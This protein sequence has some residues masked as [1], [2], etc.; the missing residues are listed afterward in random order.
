M[1]FYGIALAG[2]GLPGVRHSFISASMWF[3]LVYGFTQTCLTSL[4][5]VFCE[6]APTRVWEE[7]PDHLL[8]FRKQRK[9]R[10]RECLT[11]ASFLLKISPFLYR[12]GTNL[13][14]FGAVWVQTMSIPLPAQRGTSPL[15]GA[16]C[17]SADN[18][19]LSLNWFRSSGK[20]L[21]KFSSEAVRQIQIWAL[22]EKSKE[23]IHASKIQKQGTHMLLEAPLPLVWSYSEIHLCFKVLEKSLYSSMW[24][25]KQ[26]GLLK[27]SGFSPPPPTTTNCILCAIS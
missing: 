18:F 15:H 11:Q 27:D 26:I 9:T 8:E 10:E 23:Q 21:S 7:R 24:V 1:G 12:L 19:P 13:W 20:S 3:I 4:V 22:G 25:S 6:V 14:S 17:I 5:L 2:P 16:N